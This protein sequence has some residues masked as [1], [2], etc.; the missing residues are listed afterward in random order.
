MSVVV[1]TRI[2]LNLRHVATSGVTIFTLVATPTEEMEAATGE[3]EFS[4]TIGVVFARNPSGIRGGG[5]S[6]TGADT[7]DLIEV[8]AA[9][10]RKDATLV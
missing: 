1:I 3:A 9:V 6:T 8:S 4:G 5:I 7:L 2:I 10:Q